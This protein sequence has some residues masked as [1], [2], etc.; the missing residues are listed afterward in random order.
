MSKISGFTPQETLKLHGYVLSEDDFSWKVACK[1]DPRFWIRV[2][3]GHAPNCV[4][5]SDLT[6]SQQDQSAVASALN[7]VLKLAAV[8]Q[9]FKVHMLD[10]NTPLGANAADLDTGEW[11]GFFIQFASLTDRFMKSIRT[12]HHKGKLKLI[13][14]F[15]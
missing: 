7:E 12:E 13:C 8:P 9:A 4:I 6:L 3:K 1:S 10:I 11:P 15:D 14:D 5:L 2:E